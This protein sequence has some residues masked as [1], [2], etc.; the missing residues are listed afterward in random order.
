VAA[1]PRTDT[2]NSVGRFLI[3]PYT[4][5]SGII[6]GNLVIHYLPPRAPEVVTGLR[7]QTYEDDVL[8]YTQ[9]YGVGPSLLY[10]GI[11]MRAD[12]GEPIVG[13]QLTFQRTGGIAVTPDPFTSTSIPGGLFALYPAPSTDGEVQGIL[14]VHAPP[15]RD[16]SFTITMPTFLADSM[17]LFGVF[18][19]AP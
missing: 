10:G 2:S 13:A 7:L 3:A 6:V 16:T 17:R 19:I 8:R 5:Q 15:L 11:L 1:Q 4:D 9:V 18:R 14:K 12:T